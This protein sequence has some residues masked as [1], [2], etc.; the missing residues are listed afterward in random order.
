VTVDSYDL[1]VIGG[2]ILGLATARAL[3][4]RFP[5]ASIA[6]L[7]RERAWAAHQTGHNSG[8]I[9]SGIYYP[10]GSLKARMCRAGNA[11]MVAFCRAEG[12]PVEV[13]GKL[14]VATD[15]AELPRLQALLE[16][17]LAN[18]LAARRA[19]PGE[20][21]E[22]EPHVLAQ[23]AIHVP[24]TG[25]VDYREVCA[26]L[27]RQLHAAG[28]ELRLGSGVNRVE[29]AGAASSAGH[30]L[31]TDA[32]EFRAG[33]VVNCAGAQSDR[34]ARAFGADPGARIVP[35]RGEYHE[36]VEKRRDLVRG[37]VYPVPDPAL[38][39]LGVH[40]TRMIDGSVHVGP[41]AV[42]AGSRDGYTW[43]AVSPR[44]L[45]ATA[46]WP[47]WWRLA[48][49]YW[50]T[51][52]QEIWR[53]LSRR[54]FLAEVRRMLPEVTA[55]DLVPAGAGVRA[56]ALARDGRLVDDFLI[57]ESERATHVC[58]AP[59]PAATASLEIAEHVA[60]RLPEAVVA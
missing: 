17:G 28:V 45:A 49:R 59:S 51:G 21:R 30:A 29:R 58:N 13:C 15:A 50:R 22:L 52:G 27:V 1:V 39:F 48:R 25:I 41:N 24:S 31:E 36:L 11:S 16:R 4:G 54:A 34:L 37:L 23:A 40:L 18:G 10:P 43:S 3:R 19:D 38:P 42:P 33:W 26:A 14:I 20:V 7:E 8:V 53:S 55:E 47:G 56:Q 44:D 6:V 60:G 5:G 57:V 32:G 46:A 35:F 9:H 2:G 12:V